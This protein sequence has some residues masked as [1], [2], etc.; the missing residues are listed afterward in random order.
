MAL[1]NLEVEIIDTEE[2]Q[3]L[4]LKIDLNEPG[5]LSHSGKSQLIATSGGTIGIEGTDLR[6][7]LNLF[8]LHERNLKPT[9][10]TT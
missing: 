6:L 8:R 2:E 4:I 3:I 1:E 9:K 7:G 5:R 10:R